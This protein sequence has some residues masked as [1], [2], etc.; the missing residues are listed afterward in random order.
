MTPAFRDI[1]DRLFALPAWKAPGGS[2]V[3]LMHPEEA[4]AWL[5]AQAEA[6]GRMFPDDM[7]PGGPLH[8][9]GHVWLSFQQPGSGDLEAMVMMMAGQDE[10]G[11]AIDL[12]AIYVR[13]DLRGCGVGRAMAD[14][15]GG[16]IGSRL[17]LDWHGIPVSVS[18]TCISRQSERV[19]RALAE[20]MGATEIWIDRTWSEDEDH[21][22]RP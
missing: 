8:E 1:T 11:I 13:H 21:D 6:T 20:A 2:W 10:L 9:P 7:R 22:A 14:A 3:C 17:A 5:C 19:C 16:E 4:G 15:M 12:S 18:A